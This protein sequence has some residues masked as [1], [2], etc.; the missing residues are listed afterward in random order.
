M[1]LLEAK[2]RTVVHYAVLAPRA[3]CSPRHHNLWVCVGYWPSPTMLKLR[4]ALAIRAAVPLIIDL[5][6][7]ISIL[8][9]IFIH[10]N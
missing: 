8:I 7:G 5:R 10:W 3:A 1:R 4:R 6:T 9:I 2:S